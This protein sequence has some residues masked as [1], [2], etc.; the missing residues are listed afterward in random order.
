MSD[1]KLV[2]RPEH[3]QFFGTTDCKIAENNFV[4]NKL[5]EVG[6][7]T[8][9]DKGKNMYANSFKQIASSKRANTAAF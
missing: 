5:Y 7:G 8:Y 2:N 9:E 1:F 3:L 6:P 4:R